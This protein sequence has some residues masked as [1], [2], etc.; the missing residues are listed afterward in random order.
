[1]MS[2][3]TTEATHEGTPDSTS[4]DAV[5]VRIMSRLLFPLARLCLANGITL[6]TVEEILKHAFVQEANALQPGSPMHGTVSRISTATGLT[7]REVTRLIKSETPVRSTKPPIAT[8]VFA[9]WTTDPHYQDQGGAPSVLKRQ[10][11]T[12]SF[13][14]LAQSITRDVHPR[15]ML[16]E[17]VR[18]GLAQYDEELD[19]VALVRNEFVPRGEFQ[20]MLDFLGDNVGDHLDAAVANV[21]HD[22]SRHLEQ[23][24]FADELSTESIKVLRPLV[25]EQW[26]ALRDTM[27]TTILTLIESDRSAGRIQDQ[28]MRI[29]LYTYDESMVNVGTPA[30]K[31]TANPKR[32]YSSKEPK[33]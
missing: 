33:K 20:H 18:L 24:V 4:Q 30:S 21:L 9:R 28:R 29:G 25:A 13:E 31:P 1:M 19:S 14:A 6:A 16:D 8:E 26:K 7:R 17:L 11:P 10:G 12:P 23:A 27:V 2:T 32:K 3:A 15:S 22:G 5:L